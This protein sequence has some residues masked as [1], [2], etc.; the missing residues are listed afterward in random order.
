MRALWVMFLAVL[1]LTAAAGELELVVGQVVGGLPT[2]VTLAGAPPGATAWFVGTVRGL[3]P[4]GCSRWLGRCTD[5]RSPVMMGNAPVDERG[6]ATLVVPAPRS[7][8]DWPMVWVQAILSAPGRAPFV[9]PGPTARRTGWLG[10]RAGGDP[11]CTPDGTTQPNVCTAEVLGW[12][13]EPGAC[14]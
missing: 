6:I 7:L 5:L 2:R 4:E 10:C 12:T 9:V 3:G 14:P 8:D 1:P 13:S 11:V